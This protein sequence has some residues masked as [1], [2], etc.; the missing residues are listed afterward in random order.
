MEGISSWIAGI[1]AVALMVS[2]ISVIAP[3]NSAGRVASM[4]GSILVLVAL[5]SPVF[6][7]EASE[8]I[9]VGKA[10]EESVSE[11]V[12]EASVRSGEVKNNIIQERLASYV[13]EEADADENVC[14][15]NIVL[16]GEIPVSAIVKSSDKTSAERVSKVLE[17]DLGIP[18]E[19]QE[20]K[21]E[22]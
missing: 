16:D 8:I 10:Y 19:A 20:I 4:L 21:I 14:K 6:D 18:K 3:K 2:V 12:A 11:R 15:L 17:D 9:G 22:V 7:F 13:L 1:S 5:V